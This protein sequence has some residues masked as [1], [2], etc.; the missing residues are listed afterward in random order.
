MSAAAYGKYGNSSHVKDHDQVLRPAR[1]E[2][3]IDPPQ[4]AVDPPRSPPV[5][6]MSHGVLSRWR[7]GCVQRL[8]CAE[9]SGG[10]AIRYPAGRSVAASIESAT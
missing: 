8:S 6:R 7:V 3:V 10:R 4:A 9:V 1:L 5:D 2:A